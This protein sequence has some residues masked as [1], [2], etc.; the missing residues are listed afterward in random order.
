MSEE[1]KEKDK[2]KVISID[3]EDKV[4]ISHEVTTKNWL[5]MC[6]FM[7]DMNESLSSLKA[8]LKSRDQVIANM[9][10][11]IQDLE[12]NMM[13]LTAQSAGSGPTQRS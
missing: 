4:K 8:D 7:N 11:K 2:G 13:V 10:Q 6:K 5:A 1:N 12:R 9:H 3:K